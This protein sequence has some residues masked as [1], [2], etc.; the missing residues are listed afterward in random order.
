LYRTVYLIY[1]KL[2]VYATIPLALAYSKGHAL[3]MRSTCVKHIIV[4][5]FFSEPSTAFY[6]DTWLCDCDWCVLVTCNVTLILTLSLKLRN[7]IE[8]KIKSEKNKL[9]LRFVI[10]TC[11]DLKLI[12]WN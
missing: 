6:C 9:S 2:L 5:L 10:L 11:Y 8:N 1:A 3:T 7:K 4:I 12:E